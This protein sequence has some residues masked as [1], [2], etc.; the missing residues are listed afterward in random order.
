ME[1]LT[2]VNYRI[3]YSF[4]HMVLISTYNARNQKLIFNIF[5]R[6]KNFILFHLCILFKHPHPHL[7]N[8]FKHPHAHFCFCNLRR[9]GIQFCLRMLGGNQNL[10][11]SVKAT[12]HESHFEAVVI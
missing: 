2:I 11:G 1:L 10:E 7:C 3:Y 4:M 12:V 5:R 8:L 6:K 9:N